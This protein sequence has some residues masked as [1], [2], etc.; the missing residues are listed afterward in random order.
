MPRVVIA[1]VIGLV[2]IIIAL[3]L[4][5]ILL[6]DSY[7]RTIA[8][9]ALAGAIFFLVGFLILTGFLVFLLGHVRWFVSTVILILGCGLLLLGGLAGAS[10]T[11]DLISGPASL[12]GIVAAHQT[13]LTQ[14]GGPHGNT[15]TF[16][17]EITVGRQTWAVDSGD[18]SHFGVGRCVVLTYGPH[19]RTVTGVRACSSRP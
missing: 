9:S 11:A 15:V 16:V 6:G 2:A 19:T 13:T 1:P 10:A 14:S 4:A 17:Y 18:Y 8:A 12:Q 5:F 3:L 7:H